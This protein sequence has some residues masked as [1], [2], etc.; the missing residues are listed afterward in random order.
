M[1]LK[2]GVC[3]ICGC[4][5][6]SPCVKSSPWGPGIRVLQ[7]GAGQGPLPCGWKD[8]T[9]TLCDSIRCLEEARKRGPETRRYNLEKFLM[10]GEALRRALI[11]DKK[12]GFKDFRGFKYFQKTGRAYLT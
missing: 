6:L 8:K 11:L 5:E 2:R 7:P 9:K 1:I 3:R 12:W 4:T 10:H